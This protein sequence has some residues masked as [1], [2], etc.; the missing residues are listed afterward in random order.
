MSSVHSIWVGEREISDNYL[1]SIQNMI[2]VNQ[3]NNHY[4]W[5]D[6]Q[7]TK[8]EYEYT[9]N[10]KLT[11]KHISYLKIAIS[12]K[13]YSKHKNKLHQLY[14]LALLESKTVYGKAFANNY[15][16]ELLLYVGGGLNEDWSIV[17]DLGAT[18][19]NNYLPTVEEMLNRKLAV[20]PKPPQYILEDSGIK[21]YDYYL[22]SPNIKAVGGSTVVMIG[23]A[24]TCGLIPEDSKDG[25]LP[26]LQTYALADWSAFFTCDTSRESWFS[27]P[28]QELN[29]HNYKDNM[30]PALLFKQKNVETLATDALLALAHSNIKLREIWSKFSLID[31]YSSTQIKDKQTTLF[32]DML[33][34]IKEYNDDLNS[35][36]VKAIVKSFDLEDKEEYD[37]LLNQ[38]KEK[39]ILMKSFFESG[40]LVTSYVNLPSLTMMKSACDEL[41]TSS[42]FCS[43]N[44]DSNYNSGEAEQNRNLSWVPGAKEFNSYKKNYDHNDFINRPRSKSSY[45][46]NTLE[47]SEKRKNKALIAIKKPWKFY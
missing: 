29:P 5:M 12:D 14:E 32:K 42:L 16:K 31:M 10:G 38:M 43:N 44:L 47:D 19:Y 25:V 11:F 34:T 9:K 33:D 18:F 26:I 17:R 39:E 8:K 30:K 13:R 46:S 22:T 40:M 36:K 20:N 41:Y 35:L 28:A 7:P 27:N 4:I 21:W 24:G 37:S 2:K 15:F 45:K 1:I 6:R 23:K 3:K